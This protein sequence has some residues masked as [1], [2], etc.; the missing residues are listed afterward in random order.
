MISTQC[1][2][3][4]S[5]PSHKPNQAVAVPTTSP[6]SVSIKIIRSFASVRHGKNSSLNRS[7]AYPHEGIPLFLLQH[8]PKILHPFGYQN[9]DNDIQQVKE[10]GEYVPNCAP[11]IKVVL[12]PSISPLLYN[13]GISCFLDTF[14]IS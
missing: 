1:N 2:L 12:Q 3:P 14:I 5:I 9:N 6:K 13:R 10:S 4:T 11:Y 8:S 7:I